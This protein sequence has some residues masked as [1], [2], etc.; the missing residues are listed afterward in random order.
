MNKMRK[1]GTL[2]VWLN[3]QGLTNILSIPLLEKTG[4]RVTY[5]TLGDWEVHS[6]TGETTTFQRDVGMCERMPY[7]DLH[8][9]QTAVVLIQ[10]VH[11]NY[12]GYTK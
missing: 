9:S 8:S 6:A 10:T 1:F 7:V 2:G 11:N 5:D 3:K 12:E 4:Y